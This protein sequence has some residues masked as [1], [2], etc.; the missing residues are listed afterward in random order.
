MRVGHKADPAILIFDADNTLWDTNAVFREAQ[1]AMLRPFTSL[2]SDMSVDAE[3]ATLRQI[4]RL[5]FQ[6]IGKF[7]Y[8]FRLLAEALALYYLDHRSLLDA[9][10]RTIDTTSSGSGADVGSEVEM[11]IEE[12]HQDYVEALQEIPPLLPDAEMVLDLLHEVSGAG[13][14]MVLTLFSEG[15]P[16]RLEHI[17]GAYGMEGDRMFQAIQ[18]GAKSAESFLRFREIGRGMLDTACADQA[19]TV[20]I[21]D[22]LKREIKCGNQIGATTVYIPAAFLGKEKPTAEDES[23]TYRLPDLG[24]LPPLLHELNLL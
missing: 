21:G 8:D 16:E 14:R 19:Q 24:E 5:F 23:P 13:S 18:I 9:V 6:R 22:A 1:R 2:F 11:L 20:V 10:C 7:E 15:D 3:I 17:L 4:D 12:A